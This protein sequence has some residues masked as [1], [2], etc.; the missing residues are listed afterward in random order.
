[1][2]IRACVLSTIFISPNS[3]RVKNTASISRY[4]PLMPRATAFL[5]R[6]A[7]PYR[8]IRAPALPLL[9]IPAALVLRQWFA[10]RARFAVYLVAI[11]AMAQ[12]WCLA[13]YRD[14]ERGLGLGEPILRVFLGGFQLPALTTISRLAGGE[15]AQSSALP[16]L[17]LA[18]AGCILYGVWKPWERT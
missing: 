8:R 13:M 10:G 5:D 4:V 2:P 12:S 7:S 1:M 17:L 14:V 15:L 16:L 18:L 3:P 6:Q 9:F 11:A